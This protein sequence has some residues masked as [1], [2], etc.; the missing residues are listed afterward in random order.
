MPPPSASVPCAQG[1]TGPSHNSKS[2]SAQFA[3]GGFFE[4]GPTAS[5]APYDDFVLYPDDPP[6]IDEEASIHANHGSIY[7]AGPDDSE[8]P[9]PSRIPWEDP[10]RQQDVH[11]GLVAP[12][13]HTV[14]RQVD[15]DRPSLFA[16]FQRVSPVEHDPLDQWLVQPWG[17][18]LRAMLFES[19]PRSRGDDQDSIR[20]SPEPVSLPPSLPRHRKSKSGSN[21]S[22]RRRKH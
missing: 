3:D 21:R 7:E 8:T 18:E 5:T 1:S 4:Q 15:S 6:F 19:L 9:K 17:H 12:G 20:L 14:Y 16:Q 13:N 11:V 2:A 10:I 22:G